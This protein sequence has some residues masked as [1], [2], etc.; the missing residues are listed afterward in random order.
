MLKS[1]FSSNLSLNLATELIIWN[2]GVSEEHL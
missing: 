1:K 2:L